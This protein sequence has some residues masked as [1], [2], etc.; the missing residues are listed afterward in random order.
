EERKKEK[1]YK[2]Q[3]PQFQKIK[4]EWE[5]VLTE[6]DKMTG[7]EALIRKGRALDALTPYYY[8]EA[9]HKCYLFQSKDKAEPRCFQEA[10]LDLNK[11]FG[12][13]AFVFLGDRLLIQYTGTHYQDI[14]D[15]YPESK[16]RSEAALRV[17]RGD[18][19]IDED[20]EVVFG[21]VTGWIEKYPKS[22]QMPEALLFLARLYQ[23]AWF[24]FKT[25]TFVTINGSIPAEEMEGRALDYRGK[26]LRTFERLLKE[27][28]Q[29]VEA[30][31]GKKEYDLLSKGKDDGI[32][33]GLSY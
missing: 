18:E 3:S 11:K 16:Y 28:P 30:K 10:V 14:L 19:L 26:G 12:G 17:I 24:L 7:D 22:S 25:H 21:K 5:A 33:Y 1:T 20:P 6:A 9:D 8:E 2:L 32:L 23:D 27:S 4:K 29:S 31:K 13:G 15:S